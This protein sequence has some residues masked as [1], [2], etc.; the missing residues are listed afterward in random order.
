MLP[1]PISPK[2]SRFKTYVLAGYYANGYE[3]FTNV[4]SV[5][6]RG[7]GVIR[8]MKL[9]QLMNTTKITHT[10]STTGN[11]GNSEVIERQSG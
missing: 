8:G 5:L 4:S 6:R 10:S 11:L 2:G 1:L 7:L 9:L 3:S